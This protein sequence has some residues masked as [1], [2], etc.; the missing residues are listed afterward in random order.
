[1]RF[2]MRLVQLRRRLQANALGKPKVNFNGQ[3]SLLGVMQELQTQH[4]TV[5]DLWLDAR[6]EEVLIYLRGGTALQVPD[7]LRP[8][9]P[10]QLL[11]S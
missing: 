2:G 1:M 3:P 9:I 11:L 10:S 4:L 5:Q 7:D 6:M 8:F